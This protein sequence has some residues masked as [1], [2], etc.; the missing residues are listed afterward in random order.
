MK[1]FQV[2]RLLIFVVFIAFYIHEIPTMRFWV[3]NLS[4]LHS[5]LALVQ[6]ALH[7]ATLFMLC[8]L[9]WKNN[10]KLNKVLHQLQSL[11]L[12]LSE[13]RMKKLVLAQYA[14]LACFGL[15]CAVYNS[16]GHF[17]IWEN[18]FYDLHTFS[19]YIISD[20]YIGFTSILF[21]QLVYALFFHF[22]VGLVHFP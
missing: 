1:S 16:L 22:Q 7:W 12:Q 8:T 13:A 2:Y 18:E 4:S 11:G 21:T 15:W 5:I 19:I 3:V 20:C 17:I 6:V 10:E 14:H 9:N